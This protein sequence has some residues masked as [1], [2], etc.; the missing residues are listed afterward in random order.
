MTTDIKA[1][2]ADLERLDRA[3]SPV[4]WQPKTWYGAEDG[5]FAAVGPHHVPDCEDA[6]EDLEPDGKYH[7]RAKKDAAL[8]AATRNALPSLL[9]EL[10]RLWAIEDAAVSLR[11][12]RAEEQGCND[13]DAREG[14]VVDA[15]FTA[16]DAKPSGGEQAKRGGEAGR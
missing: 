6:D 11:E 3:A 2:V 9:A 12:A 15:L 5:G 1:T 4:P 10:R 8:L 7:E 16:L 14:A 13:T